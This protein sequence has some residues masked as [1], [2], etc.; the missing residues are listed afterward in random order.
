MMKNKF[1]WFAMLAILLLGCRNDYFNPNDHGDNQQAQKFRVVP[2]SA[3]PQIINDLQAKTN[4][5]KVPLKNHSSVQGK[6]E[7]VFGEI[8]TDYIIETTNGTDEVFY[9]FPITPYS[10]NDSSEA[11]NLVVKT[12]D[13]ETESARVVVYEPTDDWLLNG[14]NDYQTFSGKV[15]TYSLN[16]NIETAVAYLNGDC[17]PEPC[18][19]CPT[20]PPGP[21]NPHPPGGPGGGGPPPDDG[22]PTNPGEGDPPT[23]EPPTPDPGPGPG[24]GPSGPPTNSVCYQ[25]VAWD[26]ETGVCVQQIQVTCTGSFTANRAPANSCDEEN[27]GGVVITIKT[28]PCTKTSITNANSI[29]KNTEVQ[30]KMDAV[31]KGKRNATNEF[32]VSVGKNT[33]GSYSVTPPK[34]GTP[35]EGTVPPVLSGNY[36]ADGHTHPD[37][38]YGTPSAGDFYNFILRFPNNPYLQ[39][40]F[41]YGSNYGEAEVYALVVYN[42]TLAQNFVNVY[43]M[44]ANYNETTNMF[45]GSSAIGIAFDRAVN[46]SSGGTIQ[47][48]TDELYSHSAL[49]MA[50]V[51]DKFNTGISLAKVDANGNLKRLTVTEEMIVVSNGTGIPKIGLKVTKCP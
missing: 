11:Y 42:K 39:S 15:Y 46:Y 34:E 47:S 14:N 40:R 19:D 50:Y 24:P 16:G 1:F 20:N 41:V 6:V 33:N 21:G 2:K 26:P 27:D 4:N 18:P 43:P 13:A 8:N 28:D 38:H 49:A 23:P 37:G 30:S 36:V 31:L 29:L 51:L 25:C 12:D 3:I 7:T 10:G 32:A 35:K 22:P 17:N 45:I 44:S 9:T 48:N 5:F